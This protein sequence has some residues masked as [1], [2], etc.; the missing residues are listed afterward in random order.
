M[1]NVAYVFIALGITFIAI[2]ASGQRPLLYIGI[3]FLVIG[4][5]RLL[6]MRGR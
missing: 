2:G 5:L 4:F 3:A 6:R 1:R